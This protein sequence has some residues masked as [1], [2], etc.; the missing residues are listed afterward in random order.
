MS[1][2]LP[3]RRGVLYVPLTVVRVYRGQRDS[4]HCMYLLPLVSR[5]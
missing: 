4:E 1:L 3:S 5:D 2:Y